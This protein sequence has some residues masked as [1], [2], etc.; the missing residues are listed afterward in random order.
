MPRPGSKKYSYPYE[1]YKERQARY[2]KRAIKDVR[3]TYTN[4]MYDEIVKPAID[5][6]GLKVATFI[7]L[8]I[9]E[10]IDRDGLM[11]E[12]KS[13]PEAAESEPESPDME[14]DSL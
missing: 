11:P 14:E 6:S 8:A 13:W 3:L 10:K 4:T 12:G 7:K 9:R 1:S 2:R 5:A